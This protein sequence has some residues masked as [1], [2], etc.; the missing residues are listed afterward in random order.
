MKK[1][2]IQKLKWICEICSIRSCWQKDLMKLRAV[3]TKQNLEHLFAQIACRGQNPPPQYKQINSG[4]FPQVQM[5]PTSSDGAMKNAGEI[6]LPYSNHLLAT[7][8][9][10]HAHTHTKICPI[11]TN[12]M[13]AIQLL[14]GSTHVT[15]RTTTAFAAIIFDSRMW[16][17]DAKTVVGFLQG[18]A[19]PLN[20]QFNNRVN[21]LCAA[22]FWNV[23]ELRWFG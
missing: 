18:L 22:Y 10:T 3:T 21:L 16:P 8:C 14:R 19:R 11:Q 7:I 23:A 6:F 9:R 5:W 13:C 1:K 12:K 17:L 15:W 2:K 4:D 20:V